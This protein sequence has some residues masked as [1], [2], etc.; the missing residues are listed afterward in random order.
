[1]TLKA[2]TTIF[3]PLWAH[4]LRRNIRDI[5]LDYYNNRTASSTHTTYICTLLNPY[6]VYILSWISGELA[7]IYETV[8]PIPL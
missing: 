8:M 3:E 2:T 7:Y 5:F 1:M 4:I 6:N